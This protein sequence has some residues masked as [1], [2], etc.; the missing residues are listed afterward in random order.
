[1]V[2]HI[3]D[4]ELIL[5]PDSRFLQCR[6]TSSARNPPDA[7]SRD[8]DLQ[9]LC[10]VA[11]RAVHSSNVESAFQADPMFAVDSCSRTYDDGTTHQADSW[12]YSFQRKHG[13]R[14]ETQQQKIMAQLKEPLKT[15]LPMY[16]LHHLL[17]KLKDMLNQVYEYVE[18]VNKGEIK[19]NN[20]VGRLLLDTMG[21]LPLGLIRSQTG[22]VTK[23]GEA[24]SQFEDDFQSHIADVLMVSYVAALVRDQVE[25]SSRLNLL[26]S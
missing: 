5:L 6:G 17:T 3:T 13:S 12:G 9:D 20:Q 10:L 24:H 7:R 8:A 16:H 19:G 18:K 25:I 22:S 21:S 15:D 4:P 2:C 23:G 26:V 14:S 1:M 11:D